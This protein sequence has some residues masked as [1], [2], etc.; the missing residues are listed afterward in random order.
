M[1]GPVDDKQHIRGALDLSDAVWLRGARAG[2][3]EGPH[4][5]HAFVHGYVAMRTSD[6]PEPAHTLIFTEAEW[7]AFV[8]GVKD[9]EFDPT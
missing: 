8:L 7:D 6:H 9:G 1:T 4:L 5:E 2:E 3:L